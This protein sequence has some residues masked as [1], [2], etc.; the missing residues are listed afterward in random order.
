[1]SNNITQVAEDRNTQSN[2][3]KQSREWFTII[4]NIIYELGLDPYTR[5]VYGYMKRVAGDDGQFWQS[6]DTITKKLGISRMTV[7]RSIKKLTKRRP[8]LGGKSLIAEVASK[9]R[10]KTYVVVDIRTENCAA[11]SRHYPPIS[12]HTTDLPQVLDRSI[13]E[14]TTDLPQVLYRSTTGT[15]R[16][17]HEEDHMKKIKE[18]DPFFKKEEKNPR[19]ESRRPSGLTDRESAGNYVEADLESADLGNQDVKVFDQDD[20][21]SKNIPLPP[22]QPQPG[23]SAFLDDFLEDVAH[24]I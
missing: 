15:Q 24:R 1:M 19:S 12:Q 3:A 7:T 10:T 14:Y 16:R 21:D 2:N 8:E 23:W 17:S 20:H 22:P 9:H 5:D 18:E 11:R 6:L 13:S 4:P